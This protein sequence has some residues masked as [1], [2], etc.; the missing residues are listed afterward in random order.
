MQ[1]VNETEK[2]ELYNRGLGFVL[3]GPPGAGKSSQ[4]AYL[5]QKLNGYFLSA[6]SLL[7]SASCAGDERASQIKK[8]LDCGGVVPF[9]VLVPIL[10]AALKDIGCICNLFLD[11]G[12]TLDQ[13]IALEGIL[14][15]YNIKFCALIHIA[16][17]DNDLKERLIKRGREDDS[18]A[19]IEKRIEIYRNDI[20]P[21]IKHYKGEGI[22]LN[23]S[24]LGQKRNITDKIITEI[25]KMSVH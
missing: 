4:G 15:K 13:C 6:G 10:E 5:A 21:I 20:Q 17:P 2:K 3:M 7:R 14:Q 1:I 18:P 9:S 22:L 12:G 23:I 24:G 25:L 11:I 8:I 19:L 16:V